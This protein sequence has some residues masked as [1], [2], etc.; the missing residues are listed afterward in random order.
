MNLPPQSVNVARNRMFSPFKSRDGI[1]ASRCEFYE[2]KCDSADP[3]YSST[4]CGY[5]ACCCA[6][7]G[8]AP[9]CCY[10]GQSCWGDC[11]QH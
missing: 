9:Y 10:P 2:F 3:N 5:E 4:C 1:D 6:K 8:Q 7:P 11:C